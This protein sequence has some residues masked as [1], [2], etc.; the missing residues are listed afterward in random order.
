M[1]CGKGMGT[2]IYH[3]AL[4]RLAVAVDGN[5][6]YN[7]SVYFNT[8]LGSSLDGV[9]GEGAVISVERQ[10]QYSRLVPTEHCRISH[11]GCVAVVPLS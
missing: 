4:T 7:G 3:M 9:A 11:G 6:I 10:I 5:G 1:R 2:Q 8:L